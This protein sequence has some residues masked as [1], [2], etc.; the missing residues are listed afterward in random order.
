MQIRMIFENISTG[1]I[2]SNLQA[3]TVVGGILFYNAE[4]LFKSKQLGLRGA[5]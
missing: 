5:L 3:S 1:K 2:V 4:K